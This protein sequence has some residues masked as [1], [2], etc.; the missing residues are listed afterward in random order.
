MMECITINRE[1]V[2]LKFKHKK[3]INVKEFKG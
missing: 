3:N 2:S 1:Q